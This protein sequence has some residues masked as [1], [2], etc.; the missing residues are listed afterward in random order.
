[1]RPTVESGEGELRLDPAFSGR[2]SRGFE[3]S[4]GGVTVDHSFENVDQMREEF[5]YFAH[6]L[7]TDTSPEADG[8]HGLVDV[9]VMERIY[10][11]ADR[12]DLLGV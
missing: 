7:L 2:Q 10:E 6:C 3:L 4:Y 11:A 1:M 5:D 12:D 8:E 9:R